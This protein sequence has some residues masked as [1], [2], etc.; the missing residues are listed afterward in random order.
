MFIK[1]EC[2]IQLGRG[3]TAPKGTFWL[4]DAVAVNLRDKKVY[5]CEVSYPPSPCSR[6]PSGWE[7]GLRSGRNFAPR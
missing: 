4:S 7:S 2:P 1:A 3:K 5:L 6:W